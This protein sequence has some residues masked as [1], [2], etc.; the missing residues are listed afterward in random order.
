MGPLLKMKPDNSRQ[1]IN[2]PFLSSAIAISAAIILTVVLL[3]VIPANL[4][5][6]KTIGSF[7][8][9]PWSSPWFTGNTL[10]GIA[11][12]LTA[13]LGAVIA[14][15]GGTFNLGGEGQIY[16]GGLAASLV[17]LGGAPPAADSA[18]LPAML[19]LPLAAMAAMAAGGLLGGISGF[20]KKRFGM[21][22]LVTSFLISSALIP[23]AD[24]LISGPWRDS[25][26]N[27]L[28]LPA[29]SK[30]L[31]LIRLL[32]PSN[33][34]VS[35]IYALLLVLAGH[36]FM[37]R[38]KAGY[39]FRISGAAPDFARFGG[40]DNTRAWIPAMAASGALSALAGFF[41]VAGTY[42]RCHAG[43]PGG[44]GWNAIAVALIARNEPLAL[45]P[46]AIVYGWL[47]SGSDSAMLA[48]GLNIET[49]SLIQALVL[50]L[51][52]VRFF[53]IGKRGGKK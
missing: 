14:F 20:L 25:S 27:L 8:L 11:L 47:K 22:E 17:L 24:H 2:L 1:I 31:L 41:A 23:L 51:V 43:F 12:L 30:N 16:L 33:L 4:A 53:A 46:A 35:F 13:S 38:T 5:P 19:L 32:P 9:G 42:G 44:L 37:N 7:F 52:T 34:S 15:R 18:A 26:G 28:A 21:N 45:L 39:R 29:F 40:I 48:S 36:I 6:A 49:S 3:L 50:L 10:D